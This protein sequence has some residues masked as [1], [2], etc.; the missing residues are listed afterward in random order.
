MPVALRADLWKFALLVMVQRPNMEISTTDLIA[1][2]PN[3]IVVPDEAQ[4][5][6][7]S[8][9]D[10]KFSQL[11]R[12]LKSHKTTKTNFIYRGYAEATH[13]GFR[14]TQKGLE[15]VRDYFKN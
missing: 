8:R 6:N 13:G 1:E 10:S 12:N 3:Y 2:L 14:A 5:A 9:P 4:G 11:V 15:F 7:L